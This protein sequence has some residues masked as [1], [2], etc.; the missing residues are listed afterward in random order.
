MK[1][2]RIRRAH[3]T[4][5]GIFMAIIGMMGYWYCWVNFLYYRIAYPRL[6]F[7]LLLAFC[8]ACIYLYRKYGLISTVEIGSDRLTIG[9][10][11]I[12]KRVRTLK[13]SDILMIRVRLRYHQGHLAGE[14]IEILSRKGRVLFKCLSNNQCTQYHDFLH[15]LI[16]ALK[17]KPVFGDYDRFS[18]SKC[19]DYINPMYAGTV[20]AKRHNS[21][22]QRNRRLLYAFIG[23]VLFCIFI[24]PHCE[25]YLNQFVMSGRYDITKDGVYYWNDKVEE[26]DHTRF[27]VFDNNVGKDSLHVFCRGAIVKNVDAATFRS[28]GGFI[29]IDKN[30]VYT[31]SPRMFPPSTELWA[32]EWVDAATFEK[33]GDGRFG[34]KNNLYKWYYKYPYL[35]IVEE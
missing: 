35:E 9:H 18:N 32:L 12:K 4:V 25:R 26:A 14:V 7:I 20:L 30:N 1:L 13:Y 34:D 21:I 2:H 16:K 28:F 3:D 27:T 23:I 5:L 31:I 29:Y 15:D 17:A 8:G 33:T 24:L 19:T 6:G 11:L 22:R 10:N